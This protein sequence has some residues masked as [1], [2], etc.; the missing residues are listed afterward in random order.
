MSNSLRCHRASWIKLLRR[1]KP[2]H[3]LP[4]AV[5]QPRC[6]LIDIVNEVHHHTLGCAAKLRTT[7]T[8]PNHLLKQNMADSGACDHDM[9]CLRGIEAS[10]Q[11]F[12][13]AQHA[14]FARF[15]VRNGASTFAFPRFA[16]D[17]SGSNAVGAQ[18]E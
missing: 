9:R 7:Q 15:E 14:K 3:A 6:F 1:L 2:P 16:R 4:Y 13:V 18:H 8:A 11:D 5:A 17:K 10:G 12:A